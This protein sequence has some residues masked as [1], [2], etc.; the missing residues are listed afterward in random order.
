MPG[1]KDARGLVAPLVLALLLLLP[2]AAHAAFPLAKPGKIAFT[3]DVTPGLGNDPDIFLMN[4]DGSNPVDL[5]P[6]TADDNTPSFSPDGQRIAFARDTGSSFDIWVMNVDGS[7]ATD[8]T[9]SLPTE[10]LEPAFSPDGKRIA[11]TSGA[12]ATDVWV[13]NADGS[14]KLHRRHR[15]GA[16]HRR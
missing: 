16:A 15:Q 3:R 10:E 6:G 9:S 13:M 14:G 8:L 12:M 7:G 1:S 5:T 2:A 11:F 4:A